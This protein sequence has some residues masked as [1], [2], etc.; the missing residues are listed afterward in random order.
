MDHVAARKRLEVFAAK[1]QWEITPVTTRRDGQEWNAA[2]YL[3]ILE[4]GSFIFNYSMGWGC[5]SNK[6]IRQV[7]YFGFNLSRTRLEIYNATSK[8]TQDIASAKQ[9]LRDAV[10]KRFKPESVDILHSLLMDSQGSDVN[11]SDWCCELGFDD[12]PIRAKEIW[13]TCNNHRRIL[14]SRFSAE[15]LAEMYEYSNEM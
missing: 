3:V 5:F 2:H 15:E 10:H 13:E 12:D 11:F 4:G 6:Q 9:A 1:L 14:E 8:I 7:P